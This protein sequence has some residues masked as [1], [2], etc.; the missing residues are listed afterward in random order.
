M[1][2]S[3]S[4]P[5]MGVLSNLFVLLRLPLGDSSTR[6]MSAVSDRMVRMTLLLFVWIE[7]F[8]PLMIAS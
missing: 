1:I 3:K 8:F 2:T 5:V 7:Y 4:Y 6:K